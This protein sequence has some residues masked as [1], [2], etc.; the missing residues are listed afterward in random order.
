MTSKLLLSAFE[1]ESWEM[2]EELEQKGAI[3]QSEAD[4]APFQEMHFEQPSIVVEG[5]DEK[6]PLVVFKE[7]DVLSFP[8]NSRAWFGIDKCGEIRPVHNYIRLFEGD[9]STCKK[10]Q[11]YGLPAK[12]ILI[13]AMAA[14]KAGANFFRTHP[15]QVGCFNAIPRSCFMN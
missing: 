9:R 14:Q 5:S 1:M 6:Y 3:M 8:A 13:D 7:G 15:N 10:Y 2:E 4:P 12:L 11:K